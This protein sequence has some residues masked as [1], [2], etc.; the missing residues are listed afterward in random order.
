VFAVSPAAQGAPQLA[1]QCA[2]AAAA[3]QQL[4]RGAVCAEQDALRAAA[5]QRQRLRQ[6][7]ASALPNEV[8]RRMRCD[9]CHICI[10]P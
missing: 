6:G 4:Q 9:D 8:K 5:G 1:E 3:P 2:A 10:L 7:E